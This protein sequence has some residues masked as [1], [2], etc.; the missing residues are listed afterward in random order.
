MTCKGGGTLHAIQIAFFISNSHSRFPFP[1]PFPP[2]PNPSQF[3]C[4]S[5]HHHPPIRPHPHSTVSPSPHP[6]HTDRGMRPVSVASEF[7]ISCNRIFWKSIVRAV[8][9]SGSKTR[10]RQLAVGQPWRVW[11]TRKSRGVEDSTMRIKDCKNLNKNNLPAK[12]FNVIIICLQ[13]IS[14]Q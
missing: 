10:V 11:E 12:T 13:I 7:M 4:V 1:F 6:I 14:T 2:L 5:F 3:L 9:R 8:V